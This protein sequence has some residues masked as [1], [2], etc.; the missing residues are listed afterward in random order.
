M[1]IYMR[2][3]WDDVLIVCI[4]L[5]NIRNGPLFQERSEK[6]RTEMREKLMKLRRA[7]RESITA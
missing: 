3:R 4:Q 6:D 5:L 1:K 7:Y 2:H